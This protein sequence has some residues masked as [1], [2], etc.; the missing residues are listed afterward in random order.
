MVCTT[1]GDFCGKG[2][3]SRPD[4]PLLEDNRDWIQ[5][6]LSWQDFLISAESCYICDILV[7]GSRCCFKQHD[8]GEEDVATLGIHFYYW[9]RFDEGSDPEKQICFELKNGERF[10]VEMF[11]TEDEDCLIPDAWESIPTFDRTTPRADSDE[12]FEKAMEWLEECLRPDDEWDRESDKDSETTLA[13]E[14]CNSP[15]NPLELL[16]HCWG[17]TQIITT[18]QSTIAKRLTSIPLKSLSNTFRDAILLTRRLGIPYI[19]IDS[20]CIIQ[21]SRRDWEIESAKMSEIYSN[22][23]L[24]LA[25]T[26]S[27]NGN[28]GLFASTPTPSSPA[29]TPP[30]SPTPSTSG[31]A[32]TTTSKPFLPRAP[33]ATPPSR[34]S[35]SSRA[36]GST[37]NACSPRA[38]S[39]SGTTS[40]GS[41]AAPTSIASAAAS[42]RPRPPTPRPP[43]PSACTPT[44]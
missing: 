41:N 35:P 38:S 26:H 6:G 14:F 24:T 7:R 18:T 37:R 12:A 30:A 25:A 32:S 19:W 29:P 22:A 2:E 1:C 40:S 21:D 8:I 17:K 39:T 33:P 4:G 20:L 34:T 11:A 16:T 44:R 42:G 13:H 5:R 43:S 9:D 36:A 28:G 3:P 27:P 31:S 23:H 10:E 15:E